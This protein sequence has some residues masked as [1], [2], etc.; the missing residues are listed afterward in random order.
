MRVGI[1]MSLRQTSLLRIHGEC[2]SLL[3]RQRPLRRIIQQY[4]RKPSSAIE[5]AESFVPAMLSTSWRAGVTPVR[6]SQ[7]FSMARVVVVPIP[8]RDDAPTYVITQLTGVHG[9]WMDGADSERA[10]LIR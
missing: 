7:L 8:N 10:Q 9:G 4:F 5:R 2:I 6:S 1:G 3:A